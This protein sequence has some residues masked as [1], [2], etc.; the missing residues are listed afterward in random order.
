MAKI[1]WGI[2]WQNEEPDTQIK[3]IE[4]SISWIIKA[5][6]EPEPEAILPDYTIM[7]VITQYEIL[8]NDFIESVIVDETNVSIG[9]QITGD[10]GNPFNFVKIGYV[11]PKGTG[12]L[13]TIVPNVDDLPEYD[14]IDLFAFVPSSETSQT[15]IITIRATA[16]DNDTPIPDIYQITGTFEITTNNNWSDVIVTLDEIL[17]A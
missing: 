6:P 15:D 5:I 3:E 12:T 1:P 4:E 9:V 13:E 14:T 17:S 16:T 10:V 8:V 7:P 2:E 11:S